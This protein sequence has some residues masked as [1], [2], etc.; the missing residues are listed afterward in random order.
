MQIKWLSIERN[1]FSCLFGVILLGFSYWDLSFSSNRI[2]H[3]LDIRIKFT[4]LSTLLK[5]R[6]FFEVARELANKEAL[7]V[8]NNPL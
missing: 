5:M 6:G 1:I 3:L 4:K 7:H 8:K 2:E